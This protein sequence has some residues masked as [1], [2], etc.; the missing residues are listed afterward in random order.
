MRTPP[1]DSSERLSGNRSVG[2]HASCPGCR[3]RF[4]PDL[5]AYLPACPVCGEALKSLAGPDQVVG[6]RLFSLEDIRS[7]DDTH[8]SPEALAV[9]MPDPDH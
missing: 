6:L 9:P 4:T 3:L 1:P 2:L 7:P 5:A 8:P